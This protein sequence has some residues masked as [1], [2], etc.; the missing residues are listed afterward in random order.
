MAISA[1]SRF[2]LMRYWVVRRRRRHGP[3]DR[4]DRAL[5][6]FDTGRNLVSEIM[7][8]SLTAWGVALPDIVAKAKGNPARMLQASRL[9]DHESHG[10]RLGFVETEIPFKTALILAPNL[11]DVVS[12]LLGW[13]LLAVIP[14]PGFLRMRDASKQD[15]VR[16]IGATVTKEFDNASS[17][18][19]TEVLRIDDG[20]AAFGVF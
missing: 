7:P 15:F 18:L 8:T 13:P 10:M 3:T 16:R 20:I 4:V 19:T 17:P 1:E 5:I 6:Y 12:P 14:D 9:Q 2:S 11:K